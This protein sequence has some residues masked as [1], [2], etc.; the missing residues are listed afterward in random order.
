MAPSPIRAMTFSWRSC[1]RVASA[2]PSA[3]EMEVEEWPTP[4]ASNGLSS[5]LG[6]PLIPPFVRMVAKASRR[7]VRT[8]WA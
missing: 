8:L 3:A 1:M 2:R 7:P 5:R 6:N 4:K